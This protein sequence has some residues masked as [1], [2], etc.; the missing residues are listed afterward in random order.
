[1]FLT[2]SHIWR[3]IA[4]PPSLRPGCFFFTKRS[5]KRRIAGV[6]CLFS[7][8]KQKQKHNQYQ[9]QTGKKNRFLKTNHLNRPH[10]KKKKKQ[11]DDHH[12]HNIPQQQINSNNSSNK[13]NI[14]TNNII[15]IIINSSSRPSCSSNITHENLEFPLHVFD[16]PLGLPTVKLLQVT[17]TVAGSQKTLG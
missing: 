6:S 10:V 1:M 11:D 16:E 5:T 3:N 13:N 2:H 12:R 14:N 9:G 17:R 15:I 8:P 4:Y 7:E